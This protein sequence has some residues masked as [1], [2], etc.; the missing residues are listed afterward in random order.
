MNEL[1]NLPAEEQ[2]HRRNVS[3]TESPEAVDERMTK[4][5]RR[6]RRRKPRQ[7]MLTRNGYRR[8]ERP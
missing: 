3:Q 2:N 1:I 5:R 6:L 7:I 4:R 8:N